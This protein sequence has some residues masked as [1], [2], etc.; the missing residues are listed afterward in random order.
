VKFR[1]KNIIAPT[2]ARE[3]EEKIQMPE[4]RLHTRP[5]ILNEIRRIVGNATPDS[6]NRSAE[7]RTEYLFRL[8][9][10]S[11]ARVIA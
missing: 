7:A 8:L 4:T 3:S 10:A 2:C 9:D 6:F 1:S 11:T 5:E